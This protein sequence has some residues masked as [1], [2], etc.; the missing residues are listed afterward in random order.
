MR[1]FLAALIGLFMS[2]AA[3]A[4]PLDIAPFAHPAS[5]F[6]AAIS[7]S[8]RYVAYIRRNDMHY[9]IVLVDLET[10]RVS[11]VPVTP[12]AEGLFSWLI[13]KTEDRLIGGMQAQRRRGGFTGRT[14]AFNRDGSNLV[15]L[16]DR[17]T[18]FYSGGRSSLIDLLYDDPNHVLVFSNDNLRGV[19]KRVDVNTGMSEEIVRGFENTSSFATD[20]TGYAVLRYD[21]S[22][23]SDGYRVFRRANG[24]TDWVIARDFTGAGALRPDFDFIASGE[25]ASQVL[26]LVRDQATGLSNLHSYDTSTGNLSVPLQTLESG[27]ADGP[28]VNGYTGALIATCELAAHQRCRA[29]DPAMQRHIDGIRAYF[30]GQAEIY[31]AGMSADSSRWLFF[32]NG[33]QEA[34]NWFVYEPQ[35]GRLR[36]I[37]AARPTL[38]PALLSPARVVSYQARDGASL[39]MYVTGRERA[40]P[41]PV[42]VLPHRGPQQRDHFNFNGM[43]QMFA[44]R[45]YLVLQPNFRGSTGFGRAFEEAGHGQWGRLMQDDITDAV[46]HAIASGIADPRRICIVGWHFGGYSALMGA[47]ATPELYRCAVGLGPF[48]DL[49]VALRSYSPE[50]RRT[51]SYQNLL[52]S[53]GNHDDA[54]LESLSPRNLARNIRAPILLIHGELDGAAEIEHSELMYRAL[55]SA[56]ANVEFIRIEEEA[57]SVDW[58]RGENRLRLYTE[59]DAFVV[60]HLGQVD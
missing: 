26:A 8:G 56:D 39:W 53:I 13:W 30:D 16:G 49:R 20:G 32:A 51:P 35:A 50:D 37:A 55:R 19:L 31:F 27:D 38:N 34:G 59:V 1:Y 60:E 28:W 40:G 47:A 2:A 57:N 23:S 24:A 5:A 7:P 36:E 3:S 21:F 11:P 41:A 6:G 45:G 42:V 58:W 18:S 17:F 29:R 43:A 15:D 44:A 9:A 12:P 4:Q 22:Q 14:I 25:N 52:R 54:V 48:T 33:P 46:R 10:N